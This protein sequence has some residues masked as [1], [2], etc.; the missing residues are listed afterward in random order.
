MEQQLI[1]RLTPADRAALQ[2]V[3]KLLNEA[4]IVWNK[5]DGGKQ[6]ELNAEHHEEGSLAHCLRWGTQAAEELVALTSA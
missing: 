6:C 5:I 1:D 3:A 4:T 2:K